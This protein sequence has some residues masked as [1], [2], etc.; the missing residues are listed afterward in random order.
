MQARV[1]FSVCLRVSCRL[2]A[3]PLTLY[4]F[5]LVYMKEECNSAP[6]LCRKQQCL[7]GT[8]VAQY[9][10]THSTAVQLQGVQLPAWVGTGGTS[11]F[12][13]RAFCCTVIWTEETRGCISTEKSIKN[14][15]RQLLQYGAVIG[16]LP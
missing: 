3:E 8:T 11:L 6:D 5:N 7:L 15:C 10:Q 2:A 12:T 13:H 16:P 4:V 14:R 9:E 1:Y